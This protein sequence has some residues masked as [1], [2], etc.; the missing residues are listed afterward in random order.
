MTSVATLD[1]EFLG[2]SI[3]ALAFDRKDNLFGSRRT[4]S[5]IERD[6]I[7]IDTETGHITT[8]GDTIARLDA[9][10]FSEP[11][12]AC[13]GAKAHVLGTSKKDGLR[14]TK[15]RDLGAGGRGN[16]R[17]NGRGGK[18]CVAGE[19]GKDRVSG[20]GGKDKL[21]GGG[22]KDT[23]KAADG[24]ADKVDCGG[25]KDSATVDPDDEVRRCE[26]VEIT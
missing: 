2:Q 1:G 10:E 16:D 3:N 21:T 20:G 23:L 13:R 8:V 5:N 6:L 17:L 7:R 12:K 22:G 4:E 9:L 25:G 14:G 15:G 18:D 11:H 26:E 19:G 24:A